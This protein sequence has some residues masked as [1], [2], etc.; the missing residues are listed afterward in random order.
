MLDTETVFVPRWSSQAT[1]PHRRVHVSTKAINPNAASIRAAL[2]SAGL[3][4]AMRKVVTG[5][6]VVYLY[7]SDSPQTVGVV[8]TALSPLWSDSE[9]RITHHYG[10]VL[11]VDAKVI[12][13]AT[14]TISRDLWEDT[15]PASVTLAQPERR[16]RAL[17]GPSMDTEGYPLQYLPRRKGDREPWAFNRVTELRY[18]NA[19]VQEW[20]PVHNSQLAQDEAEALNARELPRRPVL[21][22]VRTEDS[23]RAFRTKPGTH[24][25]GRL[26]ASSKC[27]RRNRRR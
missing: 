2:R 13:V 17:S 1:Y 23:E 26:V 7:V 3:E 15:V 6:R 20:Q 22:G 25:P 5:T 16:A 14:I 24:A 12:S 4:G 11:T 9:S 27:N 19:E 8:T 21:V 18:G 10:D